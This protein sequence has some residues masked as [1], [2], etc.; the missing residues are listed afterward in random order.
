MASAH[1]PPGR[2][3]P[4]MSM[5]AAAQ[6][7][8]M[9]LSASDLK[10]ALRRFDKAPN[11][12]TMGM[13]ISHPDEIGT[14]MR[15]LE[16]VTTMV[17]YCAAYGMEHI[18]MKQKFY[19]FISSAFAKELR[20]LWQAAYRSA[21]DSTT[22]IGTGSKIYVAFL[23][24]FAAF[25]TT[26]DKRKVL[27]M[28]DAFSYNVRGF[29]ATWRDLMELFE[30]LD[31]TAMT[32]AS[33]L[34]IHH[35]LEKWTDAKKIDFLIDVF[36][37]ADEV[38]V[39]AALTRPGAEHITTVVAAGEY[40]STHV[41]ED[42]P[43]GDGGGGG[44]VHALTRGRRGGPIQC[45]GCQKTGFVIANCPHLAQGASALGATLPYN[46]PSAPHQ[47]SDTSAQDMAREME[48]TRRLQEALLVERRVDA[49]TQ[50]LP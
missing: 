29:K 7:D 25:S 50:K 13:F 9:S 10:E 38:W 31:H 21:P 16:D 44:A 37:E 45:Y 12:G 33:H 28:A 49:S 27:Q 35:R 20:K 14:S 24:L 11:V 4:V 26:A 41:P 30:I 1:A 17:E 22:G 34:Y 18:T 48:V 6:T 19:L 47:R 23:N 15:V 40:L 5:L 8:I 43:V 46:R 32:T 36:G 2:M 39:L 3:A 42:G